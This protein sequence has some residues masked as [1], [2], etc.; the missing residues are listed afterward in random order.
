MKAVLSS[1]RSMVTTKSSRGLPSAL[2]EARLRTRSSQS[3]TVSTCNS[4]FSTQRKS[5]EGWK[6]ARDELSRTHQIALWVSPLFA[7]EHGH[8][9]FTTIERSYPCRRMLLPRGP[10]RGGGRVLL[11]DELPLLE[12]PPHHRLRLQAVRRDQAQ[13]AP[14]RQRRGPAHHFRGRHHP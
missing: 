13:P 8:D 7:R 12:L 10:L 11:C 1:E 14:H 6:M 4:P 2:A 3:G 9:R 5:A